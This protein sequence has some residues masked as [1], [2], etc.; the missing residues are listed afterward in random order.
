[1]QIE[2]EQPAT[3]ANP[4]AMI[5]GGLTN[6]RG[7][8]VDK[9]GNIYVGD[10][11]NHRVVVFAQDGKVLHTWGTAAPQPAEGQAPGPVKPG[12]FADILDLA[13][14]DD[15]TVYV[16]DNTPRVQ[17]FTAAGEY[18]GSIEPEQLGL[19][20]P[21]GIGAAAPGGDAAKHSMYIAVTG[22]NRILGLPSV[23]AVTSG[24]VT[25]PGGTEAISAIEGDVLEQPVDVVADPSGTD[26]LYAIDLKDRIVQ[27]TPQQ[28]PDGTRKWTISRQWRVLVGRDEGGSRLGISPDGQRI[29]MSDPDRKRVAVLDLGKG[30]VSYFGGEG[31]DPG[32]YSGP[33]GIAVGDDGKVYVVDRINNNVQVYSQESLKK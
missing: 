4:A 6:P 10:R 5:S 25:L 7:V 11:G 30:Q 29:Y 26:F 17:A 9:A 18:L 22:Q 23:E 32:L 20:A 12:E 8:A 13:V 14:G 28:N 27:L 16:F 2:P 19:Y 24:Q 3:R 31:Q 33:S 15:G 1:V 21:N